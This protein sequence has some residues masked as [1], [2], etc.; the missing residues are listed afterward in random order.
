[1]YTYNFIKLFLKSIFLFHNFYLYYQLSII[2][3]LIFLIKWLYY[4]Y[5]FLYT[6]I[7]MYGSMYSYTYVFTNW[8]EAK[9]AKYR[10]KNI[11]NFI[12]FQ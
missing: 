2:H 4:I 12:K 7:N 1:M 10:S 9:F 11:N 5:L 6:T 8:F 3:L